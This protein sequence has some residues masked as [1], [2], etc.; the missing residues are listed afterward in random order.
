MWDLLLLSN[1]MWKLENFVAGFSWDTAGLLNVGGDY[2]KKYNSLSSTYLKF[3]ELPHHGS[4]IYP[5]L[6]NP[7]LRMMERWFAIFS[8]KINI[9][10]TWGKTA[11]YQWNYIYLQYACRKCFLPW[12]AVALSFL[13]T[14]NSRITTIIAVQLNDWLSGQVIWDRS[15]C[16]VNTL[17]TCFLYATF[18]KASWTQLAAAYASTW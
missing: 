10:I 5:R 7:E 17:K 16:F 1:I 13:E 18:A 8:V 2:G 3:L 11:L 12:S 14:Q 6:F 15:T 4:G 9:Q